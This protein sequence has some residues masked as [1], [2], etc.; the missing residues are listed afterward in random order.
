MRLR[1]GAISCSSS[2]E[3]MGLDGRVDNLRPDFWPR[4][5]HPHEAVGS[6]FGDDRGVLNDNRGEAA[7]VVLA[8]V[9][10]REEG[11]RGRIFDHAV[12]QEALFRSILG[13]NRMQIPQPS[14]VE[15]P[16]EYVQVR[17]T[18]HVFGPGPGGQ[19]FGSRIVLPPSVAPGNVS[20]ASSSGQPHVVGESQGGNPDPSATL[21]GG[22]LSAPSRSSRVIRKQVRHMV[23][24]T[25]P[26]PTPR[27]PCNIK[28][29]R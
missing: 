13:R 7:R 3:D 28:Q 6:G 17:F 18:P 26:P 21:N 1:G 10:A 22:A 11:R 5:V 4:R 15:G 19:V 2:G 25:D 12:E 9:P 24:Q 16:V 20:S 27:K 8:G 14:V 29:K 23:V